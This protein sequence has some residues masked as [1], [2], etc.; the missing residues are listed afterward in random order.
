[1]TDTV[2]APIHLS[3][4]AARRLSI[5]VLG[6]LFGGY[7]LAA[8]LPQAPRALEAG[9]SL[10]KITGLL[11]AF[12]LFLDGHGQTANAPDTMLDERQRVERDRAYVRSHQI[13]VG[14]LFAAFVYTVPAVPLGWWLPA[15]GAAI[16]LLSAFGIA[17][18]ALPGIILAWRTPV[19]EAE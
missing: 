18:L 19:E 15:Q 12:A 8:V 6:C 11:G 4:P 5:L 7:M 3:A 1:M 13:I 17:A 9:F 16:D 10:L 14:A 2:R